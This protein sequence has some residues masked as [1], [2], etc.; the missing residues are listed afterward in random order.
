MFTEWSVGVFLRIFVRVKGIRAGGPYCAPFC[1]RAISSRDLG[2]RLSE[3]LRSKR[4]QTM[5]P[6][7]ASTAPENLLDIQIPMPHPAHS[8]VAL[9]A[10]QVTLMP[11][12]GREAGPRVPLSHGS[13]PGPLTHTQGPRW[14]LSSTPPSLPNF[15]LPFSSHDHTSWTLG[16]CPVSLLNDC[17]PWGLSLPLCE[18]DLITSP[19]KLEMPVCIT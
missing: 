11:A 6:G 3:S 14:P 19:V 15:L 13:S 1:S 8:S 12:E 16:S 7:P 18:M 17:E 2:A 10:S 9:W 5:A 4:S